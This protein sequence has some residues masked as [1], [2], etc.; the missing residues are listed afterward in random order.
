[1]NPAVKTVYTPPRPN[2]GPEPLVE[3]PPWLGIAL[4]LALVIVAWLAWKL[5]RRTPGQSATNDRRPMPDEGSDSPRERMVAW[6]LSIRESMAG[7]FGPAWLAKTT[8]EIAADPILSAT[9]GPEP[10]AQ[11][12]AFLAAADR[13][14]FADSLELPASTLS[15]PELR[16]LANTIAKAV[17][18]AGNA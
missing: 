15:D 12:I 13:A 1:M 3:S 9:L 8:E 10:A 17:P 4:G 14:K 2:L 6:S 7:T 16:E 18:T 5:R 11:L